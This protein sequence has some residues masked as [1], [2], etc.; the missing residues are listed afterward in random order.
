MPC[1]AMAHTTSLACT[2][3]LFFAFFHLPKPKKVNCE[4]S[5][6][7]GDIY[8]CL[9]SI[10]LWKVTHCVTWKHRVTSVMRYIASS[11]VWQPLALLWPLFIYVA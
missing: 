4:T 7:T 11:R 8:V 5:D 10:C 2:L 1:E 3:S 6:A 9:S